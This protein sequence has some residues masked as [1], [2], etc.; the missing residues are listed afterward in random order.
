MHFHKG[1]GCIVVALGDEQL[2]AILLEG[3]VRDLRPRM[4]ERHRE[5]RPVGPGGEIA[6]R[7]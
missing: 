1:V 7:R 2:R 5:L 6:R 4:R 3:E